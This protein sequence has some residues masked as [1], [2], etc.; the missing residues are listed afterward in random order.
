MSKSDKK[1]VMLLWSSLSGDPLSAVL[2]TTDRGAFFS[3]LGVV[4]LTE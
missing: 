4:A 1:A 2:G 3:L